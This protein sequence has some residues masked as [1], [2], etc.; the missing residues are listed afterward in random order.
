MQCGSQS[1]HLVPVDGIKVEKPL[2]LLGNLS[3]GIERRLVTLD[4]L[5]VSAP[6]VNETLEHRKGTKLVQLSKTTKDCELGVRH[7]HVGFV[8]LDVFLGN[9]LLYCKVWLG[10]RFMSL[11]SRN[12]KVLTSSAVGTAVK[13]PCRQGR[14]NFFSAQAMKRFKSALSIDPMGLMSALEQSYLVK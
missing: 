5:T 14:S 4:L 10:P 2:D 3:G 12:P 1:G 7:S 11:Q 9:G 8:A 13:N 6:V